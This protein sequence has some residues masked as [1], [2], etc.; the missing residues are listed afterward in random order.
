[1]SVHRKMKWTNEVQLAKQEIRDHAYICMETCLHRN[2]LDQ[3][4]ALDGRT[5]LWAQD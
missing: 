2:I 3:A 1:M 4:V 5:V